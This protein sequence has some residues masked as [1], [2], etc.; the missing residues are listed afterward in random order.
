MAS[1]LLPVLVPAGIGAVLGGLA[2][3]RTTGRRPSHS[4]RRRHGSAGTWLTA[5]SAGHC[6]VCRIPIRPGDTIFQTARGNHTLCAQ[7]GRTTAPETAPRT[8]ATT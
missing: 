6:S 3:L 7:C 2:V 1:Q 5:E 4:S 8:R